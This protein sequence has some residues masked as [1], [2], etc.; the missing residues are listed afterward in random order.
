VHAQLAALQAS[1]PATTAR[2][3]LPRI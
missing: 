1:S 2:Y 3:D